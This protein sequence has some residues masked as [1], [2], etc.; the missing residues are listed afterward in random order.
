MT[1]KVE[2]W[3]KDVFPGE[4]QIYA[5]YRHLSDR[6]LAIVAGGVLD[7][8]LA[9]LLTLRMVDNAKEA[10]SFLGLDGSGNAPGGTFGARIQLAVLLGVLTEEDARILRAVKNVRNAFAHRINLDLCNDAVQ[11][12]VRTLFTQWFERV[13]R[14]AK[15]NERPH[16][17][18]GLQ[19]LG[20]H[21]EDTPEAGAGLLLSVFTVYQAYFHRIS[22]RVRRI[23]DVV[24]T[25]ADG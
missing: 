15:A 13:Q 25:T 2:R 3:L 24:A 20:R 12:H 4:E 19:E 18:E 17:V 11:P 5:A 16:A 6:E 9:E 10:E 8:A 21:L 7:L 23:D 1:W 22:G 14:L